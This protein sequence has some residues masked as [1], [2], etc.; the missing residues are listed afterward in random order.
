LK[1]WRNGYK[2]VLKLEILLEIFLNALKEQIKKEP[3]N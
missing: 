3:Q 2:D 1:I